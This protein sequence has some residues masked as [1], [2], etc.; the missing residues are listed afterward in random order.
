MKRTILLLVAALLLTGV[1]AAAR[2]AGDHPIRDACARDARTLCSGVQ[3]GGGRIL[4][5][6]NA[7][8]SQLSDTCRNALNAAGERRE[9]ASAALRR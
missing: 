2:A 5:C 6:L 3:P 4:Q 9:G 7:H 8:S 1:S